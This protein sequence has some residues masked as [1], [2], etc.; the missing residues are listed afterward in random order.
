[1][2]APVVQAVPALVAAAVELTPGRPPQAS[3]GA[4]RG[5]DLV[6]VSIGRVEVRALAP[7]PPAAPASAA[8][9]TSAPERLSLQAYLRGHRES[10]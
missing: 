9:A 2:P 5:P 8:P 1:M 6:H 4:H 7:A 3:E 10:R